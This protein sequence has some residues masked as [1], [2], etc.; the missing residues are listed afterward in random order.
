MENNEPSLAGVIC[1]YKHSTTKKVKCVKSYA[2]T[3]IVVA[4]GVHH[5]I[6]SKI[7]K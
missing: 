7:A 5:L 6:A 3:H 1:F 4:L 2:T